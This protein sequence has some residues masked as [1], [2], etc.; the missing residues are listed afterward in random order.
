VTGTE[1]KE[2]SISG[3]RHPEDPRIYQRVEGSRVQLIN[4]TSTREIPRQA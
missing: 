4:R 3:R 1:A 2:Q